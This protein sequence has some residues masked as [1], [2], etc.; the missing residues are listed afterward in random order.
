MRRR[1]TSRRL[2]NVGNM[3]MF[4]C[5]H[6]C[7]STAAAAAARVQHGRSH[8]LHSSSPQVPHLYAPQPHRHQSEP[9]NGISRQHPSHTAMLVPWTQ[10]VTMTLALRDCC[11]CVVRIAISEARLDNSA[12]SHCRWSS[13]SSSHWATPAPSTGGPRW[14]FTWALFARTPSS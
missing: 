7:W 10:P 8:T 11:A 9:D 14:Q 5:S 1:R 6:S 12:S 2:A 4:T 3:V 13:S